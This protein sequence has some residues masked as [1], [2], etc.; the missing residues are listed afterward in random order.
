MWVAVRV[1]VLIMVYLCKYRYTLSQCSY[2]FTYPNKQCPLSTR[3]NSL[4]L[5][6][7]AFLSVHKCRVLSEENTG[8]FLPVERRPTR[9]YPCFVTLF[10]KLSDIPD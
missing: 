8:K 1:L 5:S 10:G 2:H 3:L 9:R 7:H 6:I 4:L